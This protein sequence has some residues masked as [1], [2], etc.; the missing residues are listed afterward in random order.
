[1]D[2]ETVIKTRRSVRSFASTDVPDE[3]LD[4]VLDAARSAPS[5]N[6]KQP[7]H[8]VLVRDRS[9]RRRLAEVAAGQA[10]IAKAPVVIACC[11]QKY[12]D[13]YSWIGSNMHVVDVTIAVDHLTLAA[14][15]EGLGTCWIGAF[16]HEAA[17]QLLKVPDTHSVVMIV[18]VG[19]P[20]DDAVFR[21]TQNRLP[22]GQLVSTDQFA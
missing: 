2:F 15:N 14:R 7:W 12:T 4:R 18:P 22:L 9:I 21:E 11:G 1:M 3:L 8:F 10:F 13:T 20:A 6:N 19:Y 16:D 5:A 17:R